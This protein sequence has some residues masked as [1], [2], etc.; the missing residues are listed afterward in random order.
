MLQG[1]LANQH[2]MAALDREIR[3]EPARVLGL[4]ERQPNLRPKTMS[5][6]VKIASQIVTAQWAAEQL[7]QPNDSEQ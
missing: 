6:A 4:E 2:M 1:K 3:A 7:R 5:G